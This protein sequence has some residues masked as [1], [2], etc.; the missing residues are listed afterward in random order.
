M[1][2]CGRSEHVPAQSA[3]QE[4]MQEDGWGNIYRSY[5]CNNEAR[6]V[7]RDEGGPG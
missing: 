3:H 1:K 7:G 4:Q 6:S 2:E 5:V